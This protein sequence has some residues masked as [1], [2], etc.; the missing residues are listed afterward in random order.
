[1]LLHGLSVYSI[2]VMLQ[3]SK[4]FVRSR[5]EY[6]CPLWNP[7]KVGNIQLI[8]DLQRQYTPRMDELQDLDYWQ[9]LFKLKLI[10]LQRHREWY[11]IIHV[12]TLEDFFYQILQIVIVYKNKL[13]YIN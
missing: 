9:K 12:W 7:L 1:M 5:V 8:K 13:S 4:S 3:L 11:M 6:C 2:P 10:S